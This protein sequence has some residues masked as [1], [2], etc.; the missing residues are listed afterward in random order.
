MHLTILLFIYF[1]VIKFVLTVKRNYCIKK[2]PFGRL[3]IKVVLI[4]FLN[5]SYLIQKLVQTTP[6]LWSKWILYI[7]RAIL[8][9]M[10]ESR[11]TSLRSDE[12]VEAVPSS[13]LRMI[14]FVSGCYWTPK[15]LS[16]HSLRSWRHP[17][18]ATFTTIVEMW[19]GF[20]SYL[21]SWC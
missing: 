15:L 3:K 7:L 14:Y 17:T 4:F 12:F 21:F 1:L 20:F 19:N 16:Y 10:A 6:S 13:S 9:T 2:C 8:G 18:R 5:K 11:T